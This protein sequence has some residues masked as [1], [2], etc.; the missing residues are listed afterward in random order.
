MVLIGEL[1]K[2]A[3]QVTQLSFTDSS[4][5]EQQDK[6]LQQLLSK[7]SET[8]FGRYYGFGQILKSDDRIAAYQ[9][10]VPIFDYNNMRPWWEQQQLYPDI[11]WPGQP[12]YFALSSGTTGKESKRIP[13]TDD[14]LQS[15]RAVSMAQVG[16]LNNFDLPAAFFQRQLLALG[17]S[18]DLQERKGHLEGEISGI[19]ASNAPDW[20]DFF[21]KPGKEIVGIND[22]DARI[23][24]I[25]EAAPDWDIGA[26]AGIPS[27]VLMMLQA[28]MERHKLSS[29]HD[30]WPGL[31]VYTTGG[32]AFEPYRESFEALFSKP[33]F[34]MDTYLAS[35]G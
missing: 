11:T 18:T 8:A 28:V 22:W 3:I 35:E 17:S 9:R 21:Y 15:F 2:R 23:E 24:A 19:N 25:A 31:Q 20:F 10:Q 34:Y 16:S 32:V 1:I 14:M 13:V 26:L 12:D 7:A 33:V 4:A 30:L 29:I 5:A 27:W 6:Q